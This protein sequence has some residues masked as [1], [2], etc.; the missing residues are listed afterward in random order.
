TQTYDLKILVYYEQ[1]KNIHDSIYREIRLKTWQRQWKIYLI[2]EFN[3]E[4]F[5]LY[6]SI[7]V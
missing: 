6:E 3:P 7:L 2:N 5:D 4:W 1:F